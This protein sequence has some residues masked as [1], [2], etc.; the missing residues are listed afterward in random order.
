MSRVVCVHGINHQYLGEQTIRKEWVPALQDGLTRAN[1]QPSEWP[2]DEEIGFAF[3]GD[4]FRPPGMAVGL[5]PLTVDDIE[6]PEEEEL[7]GLW[8]DAAVEV[9]PLIRTPGDRTM[10]RMAGWVQ[11]ALHA[12]VQ[13][14]FFA[15]MGERAFIWGL[16]QV[17]KYF[18]DEE[19]RREI[20]ARVRALIGPETRIVIGHSLGSV[21]AYEAL[22]EV[23]PGAGVRTFVTLGSPLGIPN[24]IFDRLTP[25]PEGPKNKRKG[26][27]PAEVEYW[28]NIADAGDVVALEKKLG[29]RFDVGERRVGDRLIHNGAKAHSVIPYLTA[30]EA[31]HAIGTGLTG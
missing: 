16:K 1:F 17:S 7:L 20:R 25:P 22:C 14:P 15:E 9:D 4:I 26:R 8:W 3:Y 31:G 30:E 24:L 18:R 29:P 2:K 23:G 28:F 21:A 19:I 27:W 10:G 5:P 12:L 13:Y 11:R 6:E